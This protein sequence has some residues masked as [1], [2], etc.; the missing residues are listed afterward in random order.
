MLHKITRAIPQPNY[1]LWLCFDDAVEGAA[2]FSPTIQKGGVFSP[3]HD[4]EFFA[5]MHLHPSGRL[6]SWPGELE[7]CADA[8]W[9]DVQQ[10]AAQPV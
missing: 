7:F 6:I 10:H 1:R 2:D 4:P 9:Q 8:L 5:Q 3:M